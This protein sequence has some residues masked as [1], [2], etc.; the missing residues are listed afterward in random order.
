MRVVTKCDIA[1]IL[2]INQQKKD[3]TFPFW[4]NV[5]AYINAS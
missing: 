5:Y 2:K 1:T 4:A 3:I